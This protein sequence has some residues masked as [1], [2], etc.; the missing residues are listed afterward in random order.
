MEYTVLDAFNILQK[1][2]YFLECDGGK[3]GGHNG[4]TLNS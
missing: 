3:S 4:S 1:L 2:I